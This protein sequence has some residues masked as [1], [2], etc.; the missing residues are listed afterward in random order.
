MS[1]AA[2]S[3]ADAACDAVGTLTM[4]TLPVPARHRQT[5]TNLCCPCSCRRHR[6]DERDA[7]QKKTFTKW[8]NKHLKK[9]RH[10]HGQFRYFRNDDSNDERDVAV[11]DDDD[12]DDHNDVLSN[13]FAVVLGVGSGVINFALSH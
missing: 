1:S 11:H 9:V 8:V 6:T 10:G 3:T 13:G 12:D 7:I 2:E 4:A 5:S